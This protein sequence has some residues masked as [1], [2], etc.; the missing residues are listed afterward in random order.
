MTRGACAE[1][2]VHTGSETF[3]ATASFASVLPQFITPPLVPVPVAPDM[4]KR[5]TQH[6]V[7]DVF[8]GT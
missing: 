2:M 6:V 1:A 3:R 5:V 4:V 8:N 7:G